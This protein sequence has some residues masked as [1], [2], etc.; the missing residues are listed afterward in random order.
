M[1]FRSWGVVPVRIPS[2]DNLDNVI[3]FSIEAARRAG[4]VKSGQDVVITGG[5]PL[6]IAGATNFIKVE[7]VG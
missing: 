1:L 3:R 6:R 5:A 2:S 7:R 4:Y